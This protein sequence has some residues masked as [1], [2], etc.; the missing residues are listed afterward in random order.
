MSRSENYSGQHNKKPQYNNDGLR[1]KRL[2]EE[3]RWRFDPNKQTEETDYDEELPEQ[4][5]TE[6]F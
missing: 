5:S 3:S 6:R 2:K 1:P 4:D